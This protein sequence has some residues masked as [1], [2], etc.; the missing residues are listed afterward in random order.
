ML[1]LSK[2]LDNNKKKIIQ[3]SPLFLISLLIIFTVL[4]LQKQQNIR[5]NAANL[6]NCNNGLTCQSC[7]PNVNTC[8]FGNGTESCSYTTSLDG[9][10]CTRVTF[11]NVICYKPNC[12]TGSTCTNQQCITTGPTVTPTS[13]PNS[14]KIVQ[15]PATG[16]QAQFVALMKDMSVDVIEIAAGTYTG[17]HI[18]GS[19]QPIFAISRA[20]RPLLVRPAPGAA[21]VW[22]GAGTAGDGWF[23]AGDWHTGGS[24]ITDYITFD[25][26][27]TGGSFTLQNYALGQSGLVSTFWTDHV[28]FNGFRVRNVTGIA[29]GQTSWAVYLSSDD[30]HRGG[31]L[32]FNNWNVA[33]SGHSISGFQAYHATSGLPI[34]V[35]LK[36][37]IV[38]GAHVAMLAWG[39]VSGVD[40]ENWIITN[41]DYA[42]NTD[43]IAAGILK[44]NTASGSTYAPIIKAPFVDGGGNVWK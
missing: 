5:Q 12:S 3:L 4:V 44:N 25:P 29:G 23:Y 27:G 20:A 40:V 41:S 18:G 30:T 32:T 22:N 39:D 28:T 43:G 36:G 16:T 15:F 21:V 2:F 7:T 10:A 33:V 34:G 1:V 26:A 19:G 11:P 9:S 38:D 24:T 42:V 31:N 17:W 13:T 37:W 8:S 14:L 35:T 6:L